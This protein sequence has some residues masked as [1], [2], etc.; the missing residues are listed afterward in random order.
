MKKLFKKKQKEINKI[1]RAYNKSLENDH[2]FLGR[3]YLRQYSS[4]ISEFSDGSGAMWYGVIRVYDKVTNTYK[5]ILCDTYDVR[6]KL[7]FEVN[8]FI[9]RDLR[10]DI[11]KAIALGI[12]YRNVP[13]DPSKAKPFY[14]HYNKNYSYKRYG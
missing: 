13:H 12:D 6:R 2:A 9:I 1:V 10:Y 4:G 14:E 11:H 5:S 8:D 7:F 3:I